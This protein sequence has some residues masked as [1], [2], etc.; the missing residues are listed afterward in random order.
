MEATYNADGTVNR[1][2]INDGLTDMLA[3]RGITRI[4]DESLNELTHL[5]SD[6]LDK[7][8]KEND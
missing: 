6:F 4:S 8:L 2:G 3:I 7:T 5:V 1:Y